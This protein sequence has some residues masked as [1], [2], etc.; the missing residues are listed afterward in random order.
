MQGLRSRQTYLEVCAELAAVA[1]LNY[2]PNRR[3]ELHIH[4]LTC[5]I[6][7][8]WVRISKH[9]HNKPIFGGESAGRSTGRD[10]G[11]LLDDLP[12]LLLHDLARPLSDRRDG[13][14]ARV[15]QPP[16]VADE[17]AGDVLERRRQDGLPA[18]RDRHA[19]QGLLVDM[20]IRIVCR[21][22]R[23]LACRRRQVNE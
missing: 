7:D 12:E 4:A 6:P 5:R 22:V 20:G 1:M 2:A 13:H 11:H 21:V 17:H 14:Q 9:G 19:V 15:P 8:S 3:V 18:E 23:R 16:V 10:E